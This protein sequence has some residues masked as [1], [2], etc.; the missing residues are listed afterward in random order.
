MS[1]HQPELCALP[2]PCLCQEL[3]LF[4]GPHGIFLK[5]SRSDDTQAAIVAV[6]MRAGH[7]CGQIVRIFRTCAQG[8]RSQRCPHSA[9]PPNHPPTHPPTHPPRYTYTHIVRLLILRPF[10]EPV[11]LPPPRLQAQTG[12]GAHDAHPVRRSIASTPSI[13]TCR[14]PRDR[15]DTKGTVF[16]TKT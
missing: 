2:V 6:R 10:L 13:L 11:S 1:W 16:T 7:D 14:S 9:H 12:Q 8:A 15:E 4:E 5:L 3:T